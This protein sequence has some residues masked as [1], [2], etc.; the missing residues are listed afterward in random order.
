MH[1][2]FTMRRS[3]AQGPASGTL[4]L[5]VVHPV[6]RAPKGSASLKVNPPRV[7]NLDAQD[8]DAQDNCLPRLSIILGVKVSR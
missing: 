5:K 6:E 7:A 1:A 3:T 8:R 2:F 4:V